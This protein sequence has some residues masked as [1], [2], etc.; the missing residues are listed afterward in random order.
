MNSLYQPDLGSEKEK[1]ERER[2]KNPMIR[3]LA[4]AVDSLGCHGD[5]TAPALYADNVQEG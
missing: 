5:I 1:T 2:E 3:G 4:K